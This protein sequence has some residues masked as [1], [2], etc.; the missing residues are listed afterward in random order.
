MDYDK[1]NQVHDY[2]VEEIFPHLSHHMAISSFDDYL[3]RVSFLPACHWL[4]EMN[5]IKV[6]R[7]PFVV[8]PA[9]FVF[10]YKKHC[11][12][13][14]CPAK[15]EDGVHRIIYQISPTL[16]LEAALWV[17]VENKDTNAY[18]SMFICFKEDKELIKFFTEVTPIRKTG[19]TEENKLKGFA[20]FADRT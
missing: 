8:D 7:V 4:R 16:H 2:W 10:T 5:L 1:L 12:A 14:A 9:K 15:A 13:Y 17:W 18:L 3:K 20:G 11:V 19:N 6:L